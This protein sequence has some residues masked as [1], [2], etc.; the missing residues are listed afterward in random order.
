MRKTFED[1]DAFK[2]AVDLMVDIYQ[3]T[4]NFPKREH[5]GLAAQLRRASVSVL[6]N[7]AEGQGR[8]TPGEWRQMLSHAR[9]SLYEIEAQVIACVAMNLLDKPAAQRLRTGAKRAA[10]PLSG[11]IAYVRSRENRQQAIGNRQP[12]TGNR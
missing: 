12:A 6:S 4:A 8:L 9:G 7:I 3:A 1:L 5:Y 2:Y 10:K 11:L